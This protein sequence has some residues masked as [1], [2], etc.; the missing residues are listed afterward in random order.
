MTHDTSRPRPAGPRAPV[1]DGPA[2]N[3][4][5]EHL[6]AA[7][8]VVPEIAVMADSARRLRVLL[9]DDEPALL[10]A[11]AEIVRDD[12]DVVLARSA[13]EAQEHLAEMFDAI[14]CDLAMPG[15]SG[16]D[17]Y[18][19]IAEHRLALAPRVIFMTGGAL[20]AATRRRLERHRG[21]VLSKPFPEEE[22]LAS[23]SRVLRSD[24]QVP[25]VGR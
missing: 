25:A 3:P 8:P 19:W 14:V 24:A 6:V 23:L 4:M 15:R 5:P 21:E 12:Y 13:D 11:L 22:L 1:P 7:G 9:V 2:V 18:D 10:R 20:S 16:A 17:L